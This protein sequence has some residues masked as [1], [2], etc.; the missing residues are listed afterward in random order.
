MDNKNIGNLAELKF[1]FK[2]FEMGFIVSKP[3]G[4]NARYDFIVDLDGNLFRVQIKATNTKIGNGYRFMLSYGSGGKQFYTQNEIDILYA[5]VVPE[6]IWYTFPMKLIEGKKTIKVFPSDPNCQY[7]PFKNPL[8]SNQLRKFK[9]K[10]TGAIYPTK[11]GFQV[12]FGS[13]ITR[14]FKTIEDAQI[15]LKK[16]QGQ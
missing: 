13:K 3:F 6:N 4:E 9:N 16:L 11:Y 12:R 1:Q 2:A 15:C 5:Y 7:A 10:K 14:H 8:K